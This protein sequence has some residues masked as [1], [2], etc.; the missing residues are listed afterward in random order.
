MQEEST[1]RVWNA[2]TSV[3][4]HPMQQIYSVSRIGIASR[5]GR[6]LEKHLLCLCDQ[7]TASSPDCKLWV[8]K[9]FILLGK[10]KAK[11]TGAGS[12]CM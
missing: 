2:K 7:I 4:S 10:H 12:G 6:K 9:V 11:L 8:H 3:R 1:L 5:G